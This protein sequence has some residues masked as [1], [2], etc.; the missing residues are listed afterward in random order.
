[1]SAYT[2]KEEIRSHLPV[3]TIEVASDSLLDEM[4][5]TASDIV[6]ANISSIYITPLSEPCDAII[7]HIATFLSITLILSS[8]YTEES[9]T[10]KRLL[11]TMGKQANDL[12]EKVKNCDI[13]LTNAKLK[14]IRKVRL[15]RDGLKRSDKGRSQ[16]YIPGEAVEDGGDDR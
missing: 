14:D 10:A 3:I 9:D 6:D 12:L 11:E 7:S 15:H 5:E 4:I 1:M 8:I 13:P 16:F 2:T